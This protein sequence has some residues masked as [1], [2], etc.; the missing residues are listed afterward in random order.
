MVVLGVDAH[1]R[2]HTIVAADEAGA[3]VASV[4]VP[5]IPVGHL[6][7]LRWAGGWDQRRWAMEDCRHLSRRFEAELVSA[8]ESVVR[9]PPKMMAATRRSARTRGKSD[10]ID[11]LAVARAALRE[12]DLPV[13]RLD[14]PAREV[15][16]LGDYRENLIRERTAIQNRL[17]WRLHE[18][19]PGFDPPAGSLN[20]L[21]ILGHIDKLL[22]ADHGVV[23]TLARAEVTR[24]RHL[25]AE[26]N[27]L[28][29][30]IATRV[31]VIAPSLL[32][33][34][35]CGALT[36]A[37]LVGETADITRFHSRDA[38]AMWTGVAPIPVWSANTQ[39]FR[40]NR[41]GN[42]QTNAALHRI[43]ITQMRVHPPAQQ[44]ITRR[45]AAGNT[46]PEALRALKRRLADV[47]YRTM[48]NDAQTRAA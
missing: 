43:A 30:E 25:T 18:L 16:L 29:A 45:L 20:R 12:P 3:E 32:N 37:K 46:K 34:P 23:A 42:R 9:V 8:G 41:G 14:G 33:L 40:L 39:R 11:A 31:A 36:A 28:Q 22:E 5:A 13:A 38:Y 10:P 4:T 2:S 47:V 26:A 48:L 6:R 35:G 21:V 24:I 19:A 17:R 15:K 1:K 27:R 7:A 44:F